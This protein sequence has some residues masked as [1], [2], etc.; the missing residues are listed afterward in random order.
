MNQFDR[1]KR[2][3]NAEYQKIVAK[4]KKLM[5]EFPKFIEEEKIKK[6]QK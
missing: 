2:A 1:D 6:S 4:N 5:E 3:T